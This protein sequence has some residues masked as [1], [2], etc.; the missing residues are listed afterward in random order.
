MSV[1]VSATDAEKNTTTPLSWM[2]QRHLESHLMQNKV[3]FSRPSYGISTTDRQFAIMN[4][5]TDPQIM[6]DLNKGHA[7]LSHPFPTPS[8]TPLEKGN[9]ILLDIK[10]TSNISDMHPKL[11]SD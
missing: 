4:N 3:F 8:P 10:L 7:L 5:F 9:K 2:L 6:K 1:N 11:W